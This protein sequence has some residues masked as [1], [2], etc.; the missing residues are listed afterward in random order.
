MTI[1]CRAP[2]LVHVVDIAPCHL[3]KHD[4]VAKQPIHNPEPT[5][6]NASVQSLAPLWPHTAAIPAW[7]PALTTQQTYMHTCGVTQCLLTAALTS[8]QPQ[9]PG[10][11]AAR[12]SPLADCAPE[13]ATQPHVQP[14]RLGT[15]LCAHTGASH[16]GRQLT[17]R[18]DSTTRSQ[19]GMPTAVHILWPPPSVCDVPGDTTCPD[20][21]DHPCSCSSV[22]CWT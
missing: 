5:P 19:G 3:Q 12:A 14:L 20:T 21:D 1:S 9:G 8:A 22:Q 2:R 11:R 18:G 17:H 7:S 6:P 15:A 13:A 10:P 4:H 16:R